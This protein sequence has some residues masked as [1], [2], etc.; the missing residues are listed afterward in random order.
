MKCAGY[1]YKGGVNMYMRACRWCDERNGVSFV[2]VKCL[3]EYRVWRS[4]RWRSWLRVGL[5]WFGYGLAAL[6]FGGCLWV[7]LYLCNL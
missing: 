1:Q 2:C 6:M 4:W 7:L 3:S 5:A